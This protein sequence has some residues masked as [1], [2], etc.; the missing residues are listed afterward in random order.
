[1]GLGQSLPH[2]YGK[3]NWDFD[4]FGEERSPGLKSR[5]W[6]LLYV[7]KRIRGF[8]T[9]YDLLDC[10]SK[11]L[12]IQ[13]LLYR[14]LG[15]KKVKL[16]TNTPDYWNKRD[17]VNKLVISRDDSIDP[18]A[19]KWALSLF[20]LGPIGY[21]IKIYGMT[22]GIQTDFI[23]RHYEHKTSQ[24]IVSVQPGD[25]VIDAGG[26][27]GDTALY[28]AHKAGPEGRVFSFEF[29]DENITIF[30]RNLEMNP[31]LKQRV[32]I[33]QNPI[34]SQSNL[35]LY[36]NSMGP[37]TRVT[38]RPASESDVEVRTIS[39]DDFI[40]RNDLPKVDFIKMDVEGVELEALKGSEKSIKKYR[41]K[42]AISL[43]HKPGDFVNIPAYLASLDI[44]YQFF[45]G[46]F[47]I[48]AEETVLFAHC[49]KTG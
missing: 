38:D 20:D 4:R 37:S 16:S 12:M 32:E 22:A 3:D 36:Y 46:H 49:P 8:N 45:L 15:Y 26:C 11:R 24:G 9:F 34:F 10:E 39:I 33:I 14:I 47:T 2:H 19:G 25:Y 43:Y 1:M 48:H 29:V 31:A 27:W 44:G 5:L 7:L 42:L 21:P 30:H 28:F 23:L 17:A 6:W 13:I 41:P 35:P 18:A 40:S